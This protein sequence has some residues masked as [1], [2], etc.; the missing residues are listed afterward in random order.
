VPAL[1]FERT[2]THGPLTRIFSSVDILNRE[3]QHFHV[4]DQRVEIQARAERQIAKYLRSVST[5]LAVRSTSAR[6]TIVCGRSASTPRS[7]RAT[8]S[9]RSMPSTSAAAGRGRA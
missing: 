8:R 3:N 4:D 1:E 5:P 9:S 2:F 6:W 7:I